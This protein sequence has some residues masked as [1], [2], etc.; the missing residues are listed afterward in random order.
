M[1]WCAAAFTWSEPRAAHGGGAVDHEREVERRFAVALWPALRGDLD[2][3]VDDL[4]LAKHVEDAL[5]GGDMQR[6]VQA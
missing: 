4:R 1:I 5:A 6:V 2:Q 3:Q